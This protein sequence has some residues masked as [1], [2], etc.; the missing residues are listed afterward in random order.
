MSETLSGA[1]RPILYNPVTGTV[2]AQRNDGTAT[3]GNARG[4]N[5]VDFQTFRSGATEV[6]SG[7]FS[8]IVGGLS[9]L[10]PGYAGAV[11]GGQGNNADG[12]VSWVPGG[13]L[14]STRFRYGSGAWA[15]GMFTARG[16]AQAFEMV[17]R[18][19]SVD[20]TAVVLTAD[21]A[22]HGVGNQLLLANNS[23][24]TALLLVSAR[25]TGGS[26]GTVGDSAHWVIHV[27]GKRGANAAAT[28]LSRVFILDAFRD[29]G[30]STWGLAV[31]ADTTNG[32][33]IVQG[34]GEANK[35]IRW[36]ARWSGV[37]VAG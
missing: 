20:A 2:Q 8:V 31:N 7:Q 17:L 30:A 36:D 9:N 6:A 15:S 13:I 35:T 1:Q 34:V 29:T 21:N 37:E 33:M 16:D 27:A 32:G 5:A 28:V 25:Q 11:L 14:A 12:T 23:T 10:A 18:R 4:A 19:Q 3:G 22:V 26:S 24:I